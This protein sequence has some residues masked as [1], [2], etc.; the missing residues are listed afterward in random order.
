MKIPSLEE[1]VA[2]IPT[3]NNKVGIT[4]IYEF[5]K[6]YRDFEQLYMKNG[7]SW[8]DICPLETLQEEIDWYKRT[9]SKLGRNL[10]DL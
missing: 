1:I 8:V 2:I 7:V 10:S 6:E 5:L 4:Y 3:T 9:F